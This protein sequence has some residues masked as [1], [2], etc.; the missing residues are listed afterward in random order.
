MISHCSC[1]SPAFQRTLNRSRP[2]PLNSCRSS[3]AIDCF[4]LLVT[5]PISHTAHSHLENNR[6]RAQFRIIRAIYP[7]MGHGQADR[8][9]FSFP[10]R[11]I[12]VHVCLE[13][14]FL[15]DQPRTEKK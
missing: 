12:P 4:T 11:S 3:I 6:P 9:G 8:I 15:Q 7:K 1:W 5:F 13:E 14:N 10:T 2:K